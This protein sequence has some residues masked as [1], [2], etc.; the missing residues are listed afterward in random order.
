MSWG[1]HDQVDGVLYVAGRERVGD[2][3]VDLALEGVF[4]EIDVAGVADLVRQGVL[5]GEP[6]AVVG[7]AVTHWPC[8]RRWQTPQKIERT[9]A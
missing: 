8:I 3:S 9:K 6:A 5:L 4:A 2:P 1:G 7:A